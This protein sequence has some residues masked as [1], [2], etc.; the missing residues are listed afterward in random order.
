MRFVFSTFGLDW[1]FLFYWLIP[2]FVFLIGRF[3]LRRFLVVFGLVG[4]DPIFHQPALDVFFS[5]GAC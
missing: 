1:N 4:V 5:I 2:K 3:W